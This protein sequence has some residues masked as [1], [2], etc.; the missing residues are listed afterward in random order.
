MSSYTS[1]FGL[2][3]RN[4][5]LITFTLILIVNILNV[6]AN[7]IT[8]S[9]VDKQNMPVAAVLVSLVEKNATILTDTLGRFVFNQ[10]P[11]IEKS[12]SY[13]SK[14]IF[15]NSALESIAFTAINSNSNVDIKIFSSSGKL[16]G[17]KSYNSQ[18]GK[19]H[20]KVFNK[21][22]LL[23]HGIYLVQFICGDYRQM[24]KV[25][26]VSNNN[27]SLS[28]SDQSA[29]RR[30]SYTLSFEKDG[31]R[32]TSISVSTSDDIDLGSIIMLQ[33]PIGSISGVSDNQS[34]SFGDSIKISVIASDPDDNIVKVSFLIDSTSYVTDSVAPYEYTWNSLRGNIGKIPINVIIEDSDALT[35]K[36]SVT[37]SLNHD[38]ERTYSYEVVNTYDH[39]NTSYTQGLVHA[40]GIFYEGSG[41]Y[42]ES[43]LR[44][45]EVETGNVIK[46]I[47]LGSQY[48]GE[49]ITIWNDTIFQ[50]TWRENVIFSYDKES[51]TPFD[52]LYN[53][54]DGWGI[55][56][57]NSKLIISDGS[58]Y[59]YFWNPHT[60]TQ[61]DSVRVRDRSGYLSSL[62]ELEY[63]YKKTFANIYQTSKIAIINTETGD[64]LAKINFSGLPD[65]S[66][67]QAEVL[68]GIAYDP[69]DDRIF[70]TGK[71]WSN[72]YEVKLKLID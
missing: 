50:L 30:Q 67:P 63:F 21:D 37:I 58:S 35:V 28:F 31:F 57:D 10:T 5:N 53:P 11:I 29:R 55:T 17:K 12:Q 14:S 47:N 42:G 2:I 59:L 9:V 26:R 71:H 33:Y 6:Q 4:L 27:S 61:F 3:M 39:D 34:L 56:H 44:K 60:I 23:G 45:V 41:L 19:N 68:N 46:N 25:N 38:R 13:I 54:H 48:F 16:V 52:T 72:L 66:D 40:D 18:K 49:G 62:N 64:V 24:F 51:F 15:Y 70:I 7:L 22:D 20:I 8:G 36:D 1:T 32:D 69:I 43:V 65:F